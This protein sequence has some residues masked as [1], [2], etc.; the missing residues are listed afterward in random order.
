MYTVYSLVVADGRVYVGATSGDPKV[1]WN[2]GNG[3]RFN[4]D[5][6]TQIVS[7][8]WNTVE[9]VIH[10]T[11]LTKGEAS[12]MEC[13][14]IR[15]YDSANPQHGFNRELGGLTS[16]KLI[17]EKS[18]EAM[19]RGKLGSN[20]P[21]YGKALSAEHKNKLSESN[22]GKKRSRETCERIGKAKEK[23]VLQFTTDGEF[24]T[25]WQSGRAAAKA[26]STQAGHIAKV[27]KGERRTAGGFIWTYE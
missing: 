24:V 25:R 19:R 26:T 10:A 15:K 7:Q 20:N 14:L 11:G 18:R 27:C 23:P 5:L 3:Y 2:N 13:D 1:R 8:G 21:N 4:S 9:K 6:W 16:E 17:S 12:K 22:T